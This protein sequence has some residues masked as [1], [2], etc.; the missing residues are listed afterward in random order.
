MGI[1]KLIS[2]ENNTQPRETGV[3]RNW[4]PPWFRYALTAGAAI[5]LFLIGFNTLNSRAAYNLVPQPILYIAQIS[6]LFKWAKIYDNEFRVEGWDCRSR[7]FREIDIRPYFPILA[8]DKENRFSRAVYFFRS[9][10]QVL[11]ALDDF[12]RDKYNES[13]RAAREGKVGGVRFSNVR[14]R[15]PPPGGKIE[16]YRPLSLADYPAD[17]VR[18]LYFTTRRNRNARCAENI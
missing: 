16:R 9:H 12:I 14:S 4:G 6:G 15:I 13:D 7:S 10:R 2:G 1:F 5:Y 18:H 3:V 11:N 8:D 17:S